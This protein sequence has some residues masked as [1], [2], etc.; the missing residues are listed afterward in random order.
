MKHIGLILLLAGTVATRA[1]CTAAQDAKPPGIELPPPRTGIGTPLMEALG[2]RR[3]AR[4]FSPDPLPEQVLSDILWAAFGV[5]RPESG[6]RTAPSAVNWQEIDIYVTTAAGVYLF[7]A[8]EHRL[9]PLKNGDMRTAVGIQEFPATAP[10]ILVYVADFAKMKRA[11]EKDKEFYS[12]A[13][14]GFI[15]QNVY[16]YCAS[17]ELATC[18]IGL[19][20]RRALAQ[21]LELR[22]DQKIILAQPVGYPAAAPDEQ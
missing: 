21:T 16:L 18:V 13:D 20:K 17:E 15:S 14:T 8:A 1:V 5:N 12:A 4:E 2:K 10:V 19:V 3:S 9:I 6:R 22:D 11:G 7:N